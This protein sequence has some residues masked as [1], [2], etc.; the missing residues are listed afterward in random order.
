[1]GP[2]S[3]QF[4]TLSRWLRCTLQLENCWGGAMLVSL[5]APPQPR[6]HLSTELISVGCCVPHRTLV[7]SFL[8]RQELWELGSSCLLYALAVFA[9][10]KL[11]TFSP[12]LALELNVLCLTQMKGRS[13]C[14]RVWLRW[15]FSSKSVD[16]QVHP[17]DCS[18]VAV[19][20]I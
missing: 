5:A 14:Y 20:G 3:L 1:M 2:S 10:H 16:V 6:C 19:T 17:W 12:P 7:S 11:C 8:K 15:L 13:C 4:N 18:I 9:L